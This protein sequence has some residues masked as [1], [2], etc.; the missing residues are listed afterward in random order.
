MNKKK[1]KVVIFKKK[2]DPQKSI[3]IISIAYKDSERE[4]EK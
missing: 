4:I 3:R 1:K 2:T